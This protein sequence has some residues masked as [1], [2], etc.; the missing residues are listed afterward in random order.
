MKRLL[1]TV[2]ITGAL[3]STQ[4]DAQ[5]IVLVDVDHLLQNMDEYRQAQQKLDEIAQIWNREVES[6]Y[7]AIK[8]MYNKYQADQVLLSEAKRKAREDEIIEAEKE[9][10]EFQREKFGPEGE[11]F[12]RRQELINPIHDKLYSAI[13]KYATSRGVDIILDK[14]SATG[15]LFANEK[16]DKTEEIK[17]ALK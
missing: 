11:L 7:D 8:T 5:K 3:L 10:R 14:N 13:E 2:F 9:A 4:V 1:L 16:Y 15:I 12:V 6:K 17:K